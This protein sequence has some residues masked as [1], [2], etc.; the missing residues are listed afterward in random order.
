MIASAVHSR[1]NVFRSVCSVIKV[2][3]TLI[4]CVQNTNSLSELSLHRGKSLQIIVPWSLAMSDDLHAVVLP[5]AHARV[6]GA[7]VDANGRSSGCVLAHLCL[8]LWVRSAKWRRWTDKTLRRHDSGRYM[9]LRKFGGRTS[10]VK[11]TGRSFL[12]RCS[13]RRKHTLAA[14]LSARSTLE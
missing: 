9:P 10:A 14:T 6:G 7:Q 8:V 12:P 4:S 2:T 11:N 13:S 1:Q 3:T 5:D